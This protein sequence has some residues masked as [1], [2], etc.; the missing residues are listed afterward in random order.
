[1]RAVRLGRKSVLALT[2]AVSGLPSGRPTILEFFM[3]EPEAAPST[4]TTNEEAIGYAQPICPPI[5]TPLGDGL[6]VITPTVEP[7]PRNESC[8]SCTGSVMSLWAKPPP[9]SF[10]F[11]VRQFAVAGA[12]IP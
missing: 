8:T 6:T 7:A 12:P 1:M 2:N 5:T 11:P 10:F 9:R 3:V 4:P